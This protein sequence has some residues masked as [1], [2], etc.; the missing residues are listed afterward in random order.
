MING[1]HGKELQGQQDLSRGS[2]MSN[3]NNVNDSKKNNNEE[4]KFLK[5]FRQMLESNEEQN[6]DKKLT[7]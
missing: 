5:R 1:V 2:R 7:K 4:S 6:I 3:Q